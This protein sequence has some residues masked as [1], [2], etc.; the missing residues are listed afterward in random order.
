MGY[1][2][3]IF[4][5]DGTILNTLEDLADS[6]NYCLE[7]YGMPKRSI[8]EIRSF[9]GNGTVKLFERAVV[10]G[11]DKAKLDEMI[12]VYSAYYKEH[13][14]I[15]TGPYKGICELLSDLKSVG[16]MIAVVSNKPQFAVDD[17]CDRYF[18][19]LID[20]AV[21]DEAGRRTKP[22]PDGVEKVLEELGVKHDDAVYIGDSEVDLQTARNAAID[23]ITVGWG[24]RTEEYLLSQG[25]K[26][27]VFDTDRVF[28]LITEKNLY[29]QP[30]K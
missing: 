17:L 4:D 23:V 24:F 20:M 16:I 25:A 28:S 6:T 14:A 27:V 26:E 8:E 15:K 5:M 9:V 1:R 18:S 2:L 19:G 21:G 30:S 29:I 3:A 22:A 11:T 12:A 10:P 13:S 7:T